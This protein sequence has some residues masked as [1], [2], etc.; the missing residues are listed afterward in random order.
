MIKVFKVFFCFDGCPCFSYD[1]LCN[2]SK[3]TRCYTL[4]NSNYYLYFGRI[5]IYRCQIQC[6]SCDKQSLSDGS[7]I[8]FII[9]IPYDHILPFV[10]K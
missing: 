9:S 7:V 8:Y 2:S 3:R 1:Q 5:L 4:S 10:Y 6:I